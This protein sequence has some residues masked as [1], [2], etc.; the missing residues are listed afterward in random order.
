MLSEKPITGN[1]SQAR[2]LREAA[3]GSPGRIVAG[4]HYLHHPVHQRP[5][6]LVTSGELGELRRV[7][8]VLA[9]PAHADSDPRWSW[10]LAGGATMDLGCYVLTLTRGY[11]ASA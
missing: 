7:E 8:I 5:R 4:F 11:C 9:I 3:A 2:A 1:A 6:E 10:K